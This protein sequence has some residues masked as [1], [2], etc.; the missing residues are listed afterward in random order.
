MERRHKKARTSL[1]LVSPPSNHST[2]TLRAGRLTP[3]TRAEWIR[4]LLRWMS[5]WGARE[6]R[7]EGRREER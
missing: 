1:P 5:T 4:P 7:R 2:V 3:D 6:G